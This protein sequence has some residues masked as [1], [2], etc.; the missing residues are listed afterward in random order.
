MA[1]HH[2]FD[3][4][5]YYFLWSFSNL[6]RK[7]CNSML[8]GFLH[9]ILQIYLVLN[10]KFNFEEIFICYLEEL[11]CQC[12]HNDIVKVDISV[13]ILHVL[14]SIMIKCFFEV[15]KIVIKITDAAAILFLKSFL[16][17]IYNYFY[18]STSFLFKWLI[19]LRVLQTG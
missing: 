12:F 4:S 19:G 3:L 6:V 14:M 10:S 13:K 15:N 2:N 11:H 7:S 8:G 5:T 17:F 16:F 1:I 18:F 9:D